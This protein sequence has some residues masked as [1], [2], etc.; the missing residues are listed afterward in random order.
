MNEHDENNIRFYDNNILAKKLLS[1]L[2]IENS[3]R[4]NLNTE[5]SIKKIAS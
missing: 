4:D 5:W 2:N 3:F 1:L